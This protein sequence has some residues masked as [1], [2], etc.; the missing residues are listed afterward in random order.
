MVFGVVCDGDG[1]KMT[2]VDPDKIRTSSHKRIG[3]PPKHPEWLDNNRLML[4]ACAVV[5][6][7]IL[8]A[9]ILIWR[10]G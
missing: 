7:A 4:W 8:A 9:G 1:C 5:L 6:M 2:P 10:M 3:P